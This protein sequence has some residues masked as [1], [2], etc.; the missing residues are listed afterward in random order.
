MPR[1]HQ[2]TSSRCYSG[3]EFTKSHLSGVTVVQSSP[4]HIF[5]GAPVTFCQSSPSHIFPVLQL[6]RIRPK[7]HL[8]GVT[9]VQSSP[10]QSSRCYSSPEFTKS[11]LPDV[12][13]VQSSP[14]HIFP[15]LQ[16]SRVHQVTSSRCYSGPEFTKSHLPGVT[17]VQSSP[18]HIF[19]PEFTKSHLPRCCPGCTVLH[20]ADDTVV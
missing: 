11:H 5:P 1:V 15:V 13:V 9:V 12:T 20:L 16:L 4:S 14:S 7:S 19:G 10:S 18:S 8:P 6:S 2:V 3:S 17:V